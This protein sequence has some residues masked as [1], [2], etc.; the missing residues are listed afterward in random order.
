MKRQTKRITS[1]GII[2]LIA[3]A[4]FRILGSGFFDNAP[5]GSAIV[6]RVVDGD[7][8]K[9]RFEGHEE[10]VRL[11]GIDTPESVH[12][13]KKR[14]LPEGKIASD[15]TKSR[16]SNRTVQLEFDAQ[17]RDKYGRLLAYVWL[18]DE[19]FNET[20]LKKGYA[21][22]YTFPPNVKYTERFERVQ[23]KARESA[24][25]FWSGTALNR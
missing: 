3:V 14:N 21:R 1:T 16:L 7:T 9:V 11:I 17:E 22:V 19:L 25:G 12:P 18:D 8:I 24:T 15:Y 2:A 4:L 10:R 23:R 6:E 5:K 13:D 20:L